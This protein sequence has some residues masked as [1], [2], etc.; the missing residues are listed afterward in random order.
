M[1]IGRCHYKALI[2]AAIAG[3]AGRTTD[4]SSTNAD[5]EAGQPSAAT[6]AFDLTSTPATLA[7]SLAAPAGLVARDANVYWVD[8]AI[9]TQSAGSVKTAPI[10]G[11]CPTILASGQ[12]RPLAI[13]VDDTDVYWTVLGTPD[14]S[15]KPL[16]NGGILRVSRGGGSVVTLA[17]ASSPGDLVVNNGM[18]YWT[19]ED[20]GGAV[21]SV[22]TAGGAA[23]ALAPANCPFSLV[24]DASSIYWTD[25]DLCDG[26]SWGGAIMKMP[27]D[28]SGQP[29]TIAAASRP[30][31]I[32]VDATFVYWTEDQGV[33]KAPIAGGPTTTLAPSSQQ[34]GERGI[35]VDATNV[36]WADFIAGTV[37]SVPIGGGSV[38]IRSSPVAGAEYLSLD[39]TN[40]YWSITC[41][42]NDGLCGAVMMM[43]K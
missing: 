8:S 39:G 7:S 38:S 28:G 18:V 2:V 19:E 29:V 34:H 30:E 16:A 1:Q 37:S 36:Y 22:P 9:D 42:E 14:A 11:G 41:S 4:T 26:S 33:L 24:V 3:C 25:L 10:A 21:M 15:G 35:G 27:I 17:S 32:A 31:S 43:P 23:V 6:C 12:N 40:I 5:G 20:A 13:A